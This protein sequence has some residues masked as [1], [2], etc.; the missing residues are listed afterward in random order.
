ML[1]RGHT[2]LSKDFHSTKQRI[3]YLCKCG[4]EKENSFA[5]YKRTKM[6]CSICCSRDRITSIS[7]IKSLFQSRG[8]V[9]LSEE[10]TPKKKLSFLCVCGKVSE[11]SLPNFK[12]GSLCRGCR[13]SRISRT[14]AKSF[15]AVLREFEKFGWTLLQNQVY[16]NN[17]SLLRAVCKCGS[18]HRICL[19]AVQKGVSCPKCGA[20]KTSKKLSGSKHY[21]YKPHLTAEDREGKRNFSPIIR[22][23]KYV[24][25]LYGGRCY[26]CKTSKD[27]Q[28]HHI[29]SYA[30]NMA[31]RT[32][33]KNGLVLCRHH[34]YDF[35]KKY[36]L[37]KNNLSQILEYLNYYNMGLPDFSYSLVDV[38]REEPCKTVSS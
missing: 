36:G 29:F 5:E 20:L 13:G 30:D 6:G 22:W 31:L 14:Q 21:K 16:V 8:C 10:Y 24:T 12:N 17:K 18:E 9:L 15:E 3:R 7:E 2:L 32:D 28:V 4:I 33:V 25:K 35:H 34:H 26:I 11:V 19:T 27:L 38:E 1:K 37:G 23:R